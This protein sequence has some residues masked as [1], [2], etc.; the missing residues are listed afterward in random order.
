LEAEPTAVGGERLE[1]GD[2]T[3]E[4]GKT[5]DRAFGCWRFKVGGKRQGI[6]RRTMDD[7]RG[8]AYGCWR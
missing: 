1:A 8:R 3:K 5:E 2:K 4:E 6:R 7:G